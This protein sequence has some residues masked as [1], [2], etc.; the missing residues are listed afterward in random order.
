MNTEDSSS[1][2]SETEIPGIVYAGDSASAQYQQYVQS[3]T[4]AQD[5]LDSIASSQLA[6]TTWF[7]DAQKSSLDL[8][9]TMAASTQNEVFPQLTRTGLK[10][11]MKSLKDWQL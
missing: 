11:M 4:D 2:S 6:W 3:V 9:Q 8:L 1:A 7:I 10:H 5:L